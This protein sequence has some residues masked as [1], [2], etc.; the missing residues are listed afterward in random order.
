MPNVTGLARHER[1]RAEWPRAEEPLENGRVP[2]GDAG[3][4][5]TL[6]GV[7]AGPS[8][9]QSPQHGDATAAPRRLNTEVPAFSKDPPLHFQAFKAGW[10]GNESFGIVI[11]QQI[12]LLPGLGKPRSLFP[13]LG[14]QI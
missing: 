9:H 11:L 3:D 5:P 1:E 8:F 7:Q 6:D 13:H 2:L 10:G 12:Y 14:S 4:E